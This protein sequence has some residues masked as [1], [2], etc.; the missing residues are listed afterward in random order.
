MKA[1]GCTDGRSQREYIGKEEAS[2]PT[3]SI[4]DI[5]TCFTINSINDRHVV[6][7]NI[8]GAFLQVNWLADKP[9]YLRFDGI[10]VNMLCKIDSGLKD[11]IINT[12]NSQ[13][14]MFGKLNKDVYGTLL[15]AIL[16]QEKL[17]MQFYE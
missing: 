16:F 3:V 7:C 10:M 8:P 1:R 15:G 9:T 6:T 5:M 2:S 17:A 13:K 4:Y 11:K 14:F 12:K